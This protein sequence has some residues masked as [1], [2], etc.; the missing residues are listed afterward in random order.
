MLFYISLVSQC[1]ISEVG[2]E[3]L[4]LLEA[5]TKTFTSCSLWRAE[6]YYMIIWITPMNHYIIFIKMK[7]KNNLDTPLLQRFGH[8]SAECYFYFTDYSTYLACVTDMG[9]N[10]VPAV[11]CCGKNI[12]EGGGESQNWQRISKNELMSTWKTSTNG[13]LHRCTFGLNDFKHTYQLT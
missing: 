10:R 11:C 5:F 7:L 9:L 2:S 4:F 8:T 13:I 12:R 1:H 3:D 6:I